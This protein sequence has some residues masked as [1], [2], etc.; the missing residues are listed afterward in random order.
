[1]PVLERR[2]IESAL[3]EV[4][5]RGENRQDGPGRAISGF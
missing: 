2:L 3:L 1:M 4:R 5:D